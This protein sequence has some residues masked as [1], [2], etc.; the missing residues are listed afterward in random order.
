[1][2]TVTVKRVAS[3]PNLTQSRVAQL[4]KEGRPLVGA[5]GPRLEELA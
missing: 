1:M 2:P 5:H 3:F 4:V